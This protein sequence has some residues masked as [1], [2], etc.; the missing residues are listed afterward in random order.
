[1]E[2]SLRKIYLHQAPRQSRAPSSPSE[3]RGPRRAG[4]EHSVVTTRQ[5]S[6]SDLRP[7]M[8]ERNRARRCQILSAA[9]WLLTH[10]KKKVIENQWNFELPSANAYDHGV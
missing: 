4:A 10:L 8:V 6:G 1:V 3:K 5:R 7:G 2:G 9:T